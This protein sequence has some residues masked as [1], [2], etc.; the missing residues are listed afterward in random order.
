MAWTYALALAFAVRVAVAAPEA[1]GLLGVDYRALPEGMVVVRVAE[2]SGAARAGLRVGDLLVAADGEPLSEGGAAA[3]QALTGPLGSTVVL[4][5]AA[6]LGGGTRE[7]EAVRGEA[8]PRVPRLAAKASLSE[9]ALALR[10]AVRT[11]RRRRVLRATDALV[12]RGFADEDA[13]RA[14][15]GPVRRLLRRDP[16]LAAQVADRLEPA[17]G[18]DDDALTALAEVA[19]EQGARAAFLD[20]SARALAARPADVQSGDGWTGDVGGAARLRA[21]RVSALWLEGRQADAIAEARALVASHDFPDVRARVGMAPGPALEPWRVPLAPE[22]ELAMRS[23]RGKAWSLEAQRGQVVVLAFWATWCGPCKDEL[24]FLA[25]LV[26]SRAGEGLSLVTV[27]TDL[28][29]S[30]QA[31]EAAALD[32][33]VRGEIFVEPRVGRRFGVDAIPAVR[34]FGRDGVLRYSGEGWAPS[35]PDRLTAVV[36][37]ALADGGEGVEVAA[38][39]P[40][41]RITLDV[42]RPLDGAGH[43][44]SFEGDVVASVAR[45][46]PTRLD[47]AGEAVLLPERGG[48]G[49]DGPVAWLDGPVVAA[50]GAP[51]VRA[52]S[53]EGQSRWLVTLPAPIQALVVADAQVLVATTEGVLALDA[54]G[55]AVDAWPVA[56][57]DL[58]ADRVALAEERRLRLDPGGRVV[59]LGSAPGAVQLAPGGIW[60]TRPVADVV[61]GPFGPGGAARVVAARED[62]TVVALDGTGA[63]AALARFDRVPHLSVAAPADGEARL[64]ISVPGRGIAWVDLA[65]P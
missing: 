58:A 43:V 27:S 37:A 38:A 47:P 3:R 17:V 35:T 6:P 22:P 33:G 4:T 29:A 59:D 64:V 57:V 61:V 7:V 15:A 16:R 2:D 40:A 24:P 26:D 56:A 45:S 44:A 5:V 55:R 19:W 65:L 11:G 25:Q 12:E 36:D 13:G 39:G 52:L 49:A 42:W 41:D 28:D 51:W 31:V 20:R 9:E 23:T 1:S 30:D 50:A 46:T 21:D 8:P 63:P 10:R 48:P 62:G 14:V 32:L 34:I 60:A 54:D 18:A 53:P